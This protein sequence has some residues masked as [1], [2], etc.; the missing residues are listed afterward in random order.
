MARQR[1]A[2]APEDKAARRAEIL[3]SATRLFDAR[4]GCLHDLTM[5]ALARSA[6]LAKGTL[7]LYFRT[8]EEIFLAVVLDEMQ[9][10]LSELDAAIVALGAAPA[11]EDAAAAMSDTLLHRTRLLRLL[12]LL[13]PVLEQNLAPDVIVDF[14]LQ[15][16]G[17]VAGT[18]RLLEE[19]FPQL[20]PGDGMRLLMRL[21]AL[22]VGM[23]LAARPTPAVAKVLAE[24][25]VAQLELDLVTELPATI[26]ALLRGWR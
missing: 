14:K 20:G 17:M 13:H 3:S 6:G 24:H 23:Q 26:A 12:G 10:W 11:P 1:R 25:G 4:G 18:A 5:S 21:H 2:R 8:K 9:D 15:L 16:T 22:T 19:R 7:Y